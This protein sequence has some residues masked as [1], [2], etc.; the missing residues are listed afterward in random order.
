MLSTGKTYLDPG[1]DYYTRRDSTRTTRRLVTQLERPRYSVTPQQQ[2][3][4]T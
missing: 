3:V 1:G 4:A 2:P